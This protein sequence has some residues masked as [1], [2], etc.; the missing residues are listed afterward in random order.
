MSLTKKIID[1]KEHKNDVNHWIRLKGEYRYE[2]MIRL[3]GD[4]IKCTWE[5]LTDAIKYDRRIQHNCFKYYILLE[6][7]FR[8]ALNRKGLLKIGGD[9]FDGFRS[10]IN[11][12]V[13]KCNDDFIEGMSYETIKENINVVIEFRN[14]I[15]HNDI[16]L[17]NTF[18]DKT[19][20]ES[21]EILY[22]VLPKDYKPGFMR[23]INGSKNKLS[24]ELDDLFIEL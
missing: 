9:T 5:N 2:A 20:K 13:I 19:L 24:P 22:K 10:I 1:Y 18:D 6:D 21:I 23:D 11:D 17:G 14:S 8:A 4:S 16:L 3:F 7:V 15:M 12:Y